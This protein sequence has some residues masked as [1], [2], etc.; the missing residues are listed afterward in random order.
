MLERFEKLN[1][2]E[3]WD[4]FTDIC[5]DP[6]KTQQEV[7]HS[8]LRNAGGSSFA[9]KY[10]FADIA[11]FDDYRSRVPVSEWDD[12]S[13]ISL[14]MQN[15]KSDVLFKGQPSAFIITSG[16]SGT[17]KL[18]PETDLG[19]KAKS[20]TDSLRRCFTF[21]AHP[22]I[23]KGKVLPLVNRADLGVTS[24]GIPFGTAS[25]LTM[26]SAP[27]ALLKTC[28]F[29]PAVLKI[30]DPDSM[31]YV[32]MRFA[33]TEDVRMIIGNNIARMEKLAN[34]AKKYAVLLCDDIANG[35]LNSDLKILS[36]VR[37]ELADY[38]SPEPER[39][40]TLRQILNSEEEFT[41]R[42]YWPELK[43]ISCWLSGTVGA[44][45][46]STKKLF[47]GGVT[48]LDYGYGASEG[49]FNIPHNPGVSAGTLALHAAFYEFVPVSKDTDSCQDDSVTLLAH[50]LKEGGLY[51]MIITTFSGLYRYDMHDMVRVESFYEN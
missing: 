36:D 32:L 17:R 23:M 18:I 14:E 48:Y 1:I 19:S 29:P 4:F 9:K 38:L 12:Y 39:A 41:P 22:E 21:G 25:G 31:D 30:S 51:R 20:V 43:V 27:A 15:G 44:S 33:L 11:D 34:V 7:L 10:E 37:E 3:A 6:E 2:T 46:E 50:E 35:T 45:V 8:I 24:S 16:T 26:M 49:K 28:A 47:G 13:D 5:K 42:V 40:E